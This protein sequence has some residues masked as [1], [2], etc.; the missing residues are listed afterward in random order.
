MRVLDTINVAKV[1]RALA[2]RIEHK[3]VLPYMVTATDDH[4][5]VYFQEVHHLGAEAQGPAPKKVH[6]QRPSDED[7]E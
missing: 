1:L 5:E 2:D 6:G 4:V 7:V 3:D